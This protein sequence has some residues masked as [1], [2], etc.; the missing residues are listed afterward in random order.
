MAK[1]LGAPVVLVVD[2]DGLG[3]SA[4]AVVRGY[5]GFDPALRIAGVVLNRLSSRGQLQKLQVRDTP[6][7]CLSA[8]GTS[9]FPSLTRPRSF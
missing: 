6:L 2:C 5:L 3:R 7:P 4:A 9:R 8:L 1:W